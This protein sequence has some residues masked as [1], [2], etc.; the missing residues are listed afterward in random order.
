[1]AQDFYRLFNVGTD[2]CS[3]STIDPAGVALSGIQELSKELDLVKKQN[4]ELKNS[5]DQYKNES[6]KEI[7]ELKKIVEAL[8]SKL[9]K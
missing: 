1:M 2:S 6:S 3:I 5:L 4:S 8:K 9:D 7:E